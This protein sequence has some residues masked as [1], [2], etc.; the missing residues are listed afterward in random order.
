MTLHVRVSGIWRTLTNAFVNAAAAW[1][2]SSVTIR[3]AGSW[4][5]VLVN[6]IVVS[7]ASPGTFDTTAQGSTLTFK[8]WGGG[9]EGGG[10]CGG[11]YGGAGGYTQGTIPVSP[12][13][14]VRVFVGAGSG[15]SPC[16]ACGFGAGTGG[17]YSYVTVNGTLQ[18]IS[19]G[20]GGTGQGGGGG[21]G[22]GNG[23]G[24]NG[25]G[26]AGGGS[27]AT[28]SSGC[29]NVFWSTSTSNG[30]GGGGTGSG[31]GNR[32]GGGG[33]GYYGG[34]PGNGNPNGCSGS[35]G[36]GGSGWINPSVPAPSRVSFTGP[37]SFS[38][39]NAAANN[40]DVHYQP[41]RSGSGQSGLVVLIYS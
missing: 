28:Q 39:V 40:T 36:G 38:S 22:G 23:P 20:G 2:N 14:P 6:E 27:G 34:G 11:R 12:G 10:E 41:G 5:N 33:A 13:T 4:R 15:G 19:G 30:C 26:P 18:A 9:G 7:Y 1:R 24:G 32:G 21:G 3:D 29:G 16:G 17:Q 31:G 8:I 35:G 37:S 25:F